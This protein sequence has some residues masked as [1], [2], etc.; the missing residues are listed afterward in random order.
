MQA[1][2][3]RAIAL[4]W[5]VRCP[6]YRRQ[7]L[8]PQQLPD[9]VARSLPVTARSSSLVLLCFLHAGAGHAQIGAAV[10]PSSTAAAEAAEA[11]EEAKDEILVTAHRQHGAVFTEV[12]PQVTFNS[13]SIRALGAAD[14]DEVLDD[15]APAIRTAGSEPGRTVQT[16][17]MLVNGQR[18][19]G[20][21]SIRDLPPEA[22]R[23]IE[24]FPEQ[25]ALQYGYA[26]DQRVVNVVLRSRY[27][28]LTLLGRY[29][30]S[31][32]NWRGL[33]RAKADLV[34]IGETSH[35]T[36]D[37]DYRHEDPLFADNTLAGPSAPPGAPVPQHT[38]AAQSDHLSLSG[39]GTKTFGQVT[40]ELT[41]RI[42][43]DSV[44]SR[45]GL[46]DNDGDLLAGQGLT[47]RIGGPLSRVD[48]TSEAQVNLTLNGKLQ[49]WRWSFVGKLD[50][51]TRITRTNDITGDLAAIVLPS[52]TLIGRNCDSAA[53]PGCVSTGTRTASGDFYLNGNVAQLPAGA[54]TA[55]LRTGFAF[56]GITAHSPLPGRAGEL[57]RDEG[58]AQGNLDFPITSRHSPIGQ[59]T[60]SIN[61]AVS[62]V[63]G[64]STLS[65]I[66][67][68]IDWS[69]REAITIRG[70]YSRE[71]Q[72]PTLMQLGEAGLLTPLLREFDFVNGDTA[73]V[74]RI[75][76]DT[77]DLRRA[78]SRIGRLRLEV[79]PIRGKNLTLSGEYT[80]ERTRNPIVN[81]T[82]ATPATVAAFP[83]RFAFDG[84]FL[85]SL[86]VSPV[87]LARRDRQ[88]LRWGIN[89]STAYGAPWTSNKNQGPGAPKPPPSRNQLQV[90]LY[91]T[92]RFQDDAVLRNGM[93][94]LDLL[95]HDLISD[96]GGT[97]RHEFELQTT[98]TTRAWSAAINGSW[99]VPT[100]A[101]A[102]PLGSERL[103]FS[104][105]IMINLRLRIDLG[106]QR[107]LT[108][109]LPWVHGN[110]NISADNLFGA[111]LEVHRHGIGE[112]LAFAES[113]LNPTGRTFRITLRKRFR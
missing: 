40:A 88:Q 6:R 53:N 46:T 8:P 19:A 95:G 108:R 29:T 106:E 20:F 41:G 17:V 97:P 25:V 54:I 13:A 5:S 111:H 55:A 82:A 74:Q 75:E 26:P 112:P 94:S 9:R 73:I 4:R 68:S 81:V 85:S 87:N 90:A 58:S 66:G 32:S 45:P 105:G 43:L 30:F 60:T 65:T 12:P 84:G 2:R 42:D 23:R 21:S 61:G 109:M 1:S 78:T 113:Y 103:T 33:Y 39:S 77:P 52:P 64:F 31:P 50:A 37:L 80:I 38:T 96:R 107:W 22:I 56:S 62:R 86:D 27:H 48:R 59:L 16:P 83:D 99:R 57:S 76:G 63:S 14:L 3:H 36:L 49:S 15:L 51:L 11:A 34:R 70:S 101:I 98:I 104:Q 10:S 102:G 44:Q 47:N 93:P 7:S 72:A 69:P 35:W 28:A 91:D 24:V 110:L 67:S 89:F 18:I 100:T 71:E 92:W 79:N